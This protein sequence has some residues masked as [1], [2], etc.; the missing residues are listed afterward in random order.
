[1]CIRDR[2]ITKIN[3]NISNFAEISTP[4]ELVNEM[5]D[6]LPVE[7]WSDEKLKWFDPSVGRG[8]FIICV[9]DRLMKSLKN[10]QNEENR[11]EYILKEMLY[12]SELNRINVEIV[13][14]IFYFD[15]YISR[16]VNLFTNKNKLVLKLKTEKF[17]INLHVKDMDIDNEELMQ[18]FLKLNL[19]PKTKEKKEFGEV[20]TPS[21][22]INEMLDKL[23]KEVWSNKNLKWFDPAVGMGNF[24]VEVY[25]RLLEGLVDVIPDFNERKTHIIQNMIYMSELNEENIKHCNRIFSDGINIYQGDT[26]EMPEDYFGVGKFDVIVG[27]PPYNLPFTSSGSAQPLYH[28]FVEKFID[29]TDKLIFL[30]PSKWFQGG[31]VL[32]KFRKDMFKRKDI[33]L[34]KHYD[35]ASKFFDIDLKG[36]VN[37]FL[38]DKNYKG[39]VS[40]NGEMTDL[41]KY[42]IFVPV[43]Y[44]DLISKIEKL[45]NITSIM[46]G[47][48]YKINSNDKRLKNEKFENSIKCYTNKKSGFI[49][50]ILDDEKYEKSWKVAAAAAH[51]SFS[52]FGNMF[53]SNPEEI[54]SQTY[55]SF[56]VDDENEAKSL[57][58]YL[59]CKLPNLLLSIRKNTQSIRT[60]TLKW[61]PL[62]PLD[63]E[64]TDEK[65]YEF[66]NL[67]DANIKLVNEEKLKG[68]RSL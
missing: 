16:K 13:K 38:K 40:I 9:Y 50:Y 3:E 12:M 68:Y 21:E 47:N 17:Y 24:M 14:R 55:I 8:A 59:K 23:P 63:R 48:I 20:F 32:E 43:K 62:V 11:N 6:K 28:K 66:F 37:Y 58:S 27:N 2:N 15:K 1:M 52:A 35:D 64:W 39:F 57:L 30:T 29:E 4:T 19:K 53:I 60:K 22:L 33:K 36:G 44:H 26:L 41:Q 51:G 45:K 54:Y 46:K 65:I 67:T 34:I 61:I 18:E 49:K 7:I 31:V 25:W 5:L 10:I 56:K 42:D